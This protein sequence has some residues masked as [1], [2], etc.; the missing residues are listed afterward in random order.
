MQ[1]K[2]SKI[3][4]QMRFPNATKKFSKM[5]SFPAQKKRARLPRLKYSVAR[6]RKNFF[7][8]FE[9]KIRGGFVVSV[10]ESVCPRLMENKYDE[11]W[12]KYA[13]KWRNKY[14]EKWRKYEEKWRK[15][16][17]KRR[18]YAQKWRNW[19]SKWRN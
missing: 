13:Q 9:S 16:E 10:P 8:F 3:K 19:R 2:N 6:L 11:K 15:Y 18:K 4:T 17:E 14:E 5:K 12:R 1:L 7:I